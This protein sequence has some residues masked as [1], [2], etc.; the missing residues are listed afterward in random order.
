MDTMVLAEGGRAMHGWWEEIH[1]LQRGA[2][3]TCCPKTVVPGGKQYSPVNLKD[4][5]GQTQD[6]KRL[7]FSYEKLICL[8]IKV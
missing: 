8:E 2:T 7:R 4:K 1:M 3:A 6:P 5:S